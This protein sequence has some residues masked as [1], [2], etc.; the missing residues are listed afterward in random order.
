DPGGDA[1]GQC[2]GAAGLPAADGGQDCPLP[3]TLR[4][5]TR[6]ADVGNGANDSPG[7]GERCAIV[8]YTPTCRCIGTNMPLYRHQHAAVSAYD[9]LLVFYWCFIPFVKDK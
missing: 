3:G 2:A 4:R 5:S 6:G 7:D 8:V 1:G 9:P